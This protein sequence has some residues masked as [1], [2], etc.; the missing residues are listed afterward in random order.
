MSK[1]II[2]ILIIAI[3]LLLAIALNPSAEKHRN[4]IEE[5]IAER[6]ELENVLSVGRI[7]AFVSKYHSLGVGSYTTVNDKVS[8]IGVLGM[9]FVVE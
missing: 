9:V 7:T 1:S 3:T 5:T 8:S 2:S 4:K 6:S